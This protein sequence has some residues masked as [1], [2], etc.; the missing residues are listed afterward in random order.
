[1]TADEFD[2]AA[3]DDQLLAG[4]RSGAWLDGATFPPLSWAVRGLIPEGLGLFTGPPKAGKSWAS[5]DIALAVAGG[6]VALGNVETG[7]ARPVLLLALEDGDRRLQGRCR[8]LLQDGPIPAAL[9]YL[10][11]VT[12]LQVLPTI[13]AWLRRHGDRKPLVVLDTL[14]KVMPPALPGEGAY[15]R[16]Y[17]IGSALKRTVDAHPGA[18]LLVIHHTRKLAAEDWMDSTSGSNGLNGSADFTVNLSRKRNE[19]NGVLRVTGR[20]VPEGEYAVTCAGG[21]WT[22]DGSDLAAAARAV[23]E[24]K[25]TEG[26]GDTSA[27]ILRYVAGQPDPVTPKQ[28]ADAF[29]L[30]DARQYLKRAVDAGRLRKVGRGLYTPV[31]TVTVSQASDPECDEV[32]E[33]TGGLGGA[34]AENATVATSRLRPCPEC[35][36]P[37]GAGA[38]LWRPNGTPGRCDECGRLQAVAS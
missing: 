8:T 18:C 10:T 21:R 1:M 13:E 17:R 12:P 35:G 38:D 20:D 2:V 28:V 37:F 5:L 16:D 24:A 27:K 29:N 19:D 15:Q 30:A 22:L 36:R 25:A 23:V 7:P 3:D 26:L 9:E 4:L 11:R 14:G 33:V 31:T 6:T 32:T 34:S